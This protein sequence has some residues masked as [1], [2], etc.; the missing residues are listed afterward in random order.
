[1]TPGNSVWHPIL[2]QQQLVGTQRSGVSRRMQ[3]RIEDLGQVRRTLAAAALCATSTV[4]G[5]A[6]AERRGTVGGSV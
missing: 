1:M 4:M 5:R 6:H 2:G 3:G